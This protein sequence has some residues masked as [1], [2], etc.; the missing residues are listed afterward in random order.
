MWFSNF[1]VKKEPDEKEKKRNNK[2]QGKVGK[3]H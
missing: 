2:A 1:N 3:K